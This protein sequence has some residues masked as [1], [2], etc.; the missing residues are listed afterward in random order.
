MTTKRSPCIWEKRSI[1]TRFK[2]V[3]CIAHTCVHD[4]ESTIII[5][6]L[7]LSDLLKQHCT[8]YFCVSVVGQIT[9]IVT[10]SSVTLC[11]F[12]KGRE[13][14]AFRLHSIIECMHA[15]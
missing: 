1:Q 15:A 6:R 12:M 14:L 10:E 8:L 13:I 9:P 7:F 5:E 3:N 11:M 2:Y 4:R